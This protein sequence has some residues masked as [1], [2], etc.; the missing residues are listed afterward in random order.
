MQPKDETIEFLAELSRDSRNIVCIISNGEK[1]TVQSAFSSL[2]NV[3]LAAENGYCYKTDKS[4][5]KR[6][7]VQES[8]GW[9]KTLRKIFD[10][11]CENIE[12][13]VVEERESSITWNYKNAEA[14]HGLKFSMELY[15]QVSTLI[16]HPS[17]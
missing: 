6:L 8:A 4:D 5:W 7:F 9:L 3:W 15:K 13:T 16:R 17:K 10:Q 12:G 2:P 11:Y 14:E 1:E